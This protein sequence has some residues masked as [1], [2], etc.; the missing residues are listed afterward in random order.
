MKINGKPD[1]GGGGAAVWGGI[2]GNINSQADLNAQFVKKNGLKT[3]NNESIVGTGNIEV[4]GLDPEQ[5]AA[6]EVLTDASKGMLYTNT[7]NQYEAIYVPLN[8]AVI[9]EYAGKMSDVDGETY[10]LFGLFLYK[11]NP[12]S[13]SFDKLGDFT[14][15]SGTTEA[16]M[17]K[18]M[19]GRMY[20]GVE[21]ALDLDAMTYTPISLD[22]VGYSFGY[23][24]NY[25]T[26]WKGQYAVYNLGSDPQKF[27]ETTQKFVS[28]TVTI[29]EGY[30]VSTI[31]PYMSQYGI[32]YDGHYVWFDAGIMYELTEYEDHLDISVVSTPYF[33]MTINSNYIY[34]AYIRNVEGELYYLMQ[35]KYHLVNGNWEAVTIDILF[36]NSAGRGTVC[37]NYLIGCEE[38]YITGYTSIVNMAASKT[39]T[40]WTEPKQVAV[41]LN[42]EQY[43]RGFKRFETIYTDNTYFKQLMGSDSQTSISLNKNETTANSIKLSVAGKF[44]MNNKNI[45]TTDECIMNRAIIPYGDIVVDVIQDGKDPYRYNYFTTNTGRLFYVP[46]GGYEFDGTQWNSVSTPLTDDSTGVYGT[47]VIKA[48]SK[49]FY[50]N[51]NTY[52]WNDT[53]SQFVTIT[54]G[55]PSSGWSIWP[56]GDGELRA[57][58]DY[59]LVEN[60]GT[61]SWEQDTVPDYK[62]GMTYYINGNVYVLGMDDNKV[63]QY[64]ESTKTYTELGNYNRWN[65]SSFECA[66]EIFFPNNGD[67][68]YKIDLSK[69]GQQYI[70]TPTT[71]PY[72][73]YMYF[74][75]EYNN[76]LYL[77][78]N[79]DNLAYCYDVEESVPAVPSTDGT[80]TLKASV[81]NGQV[82]YEWVLDQI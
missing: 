24:S 33:P 57:S 53:N 50:V 14:F 43:I 37:E 12:D 6:V 23:A 82:T 47:A 3:I 70:D 75:G 68:F 77:Y 38:N 66:G 35:N 13:L 42:S 26:I 1:G 18:D 28:F 71:I 10:F 56:C 21:Y 4:G 2:T 36:N 44:R 31:A 40:Y 45:A 49:T 72:S 19:T 30:D 67:S 41:D 62:N 63:Y 34:C 8:Y 60:N 76:Y 29:T 80:Y 25:H 22:A 73:N 16:P 81:V 69:I 78:R 55:A 27:D 15:S 65:D 79:D 5:E 32:W 7:L 52:L 11:F 54:N 9:P 74:Y 51:G 17:W 46:N 64:D 61:W 59:K 58:G 20:K 39:K 48:G